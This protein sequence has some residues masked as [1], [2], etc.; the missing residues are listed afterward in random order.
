MIAF[1][2]GARKGFE[3]PFE[4]HNSDFLILSCALQAMLYNFFRAL[5][6]QD[7][8]SSSSRSNIR[9]LCAYR[10]WTQGANLYFSIR[11]FSSKSNRETQD[12]GFCCTINRKVSEWQKRR[13]ARHV[14]NCAPLSQIRHAYS[15]K[16]CKSSTIC[17][18]HIKLWL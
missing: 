3:L 4:R 18:Y 10:S 6:V 5:A 15:T 1:D 12:K 9:K 13:K 16:P 14:Y 7:F 2:K 17:I 8:F 11:Q